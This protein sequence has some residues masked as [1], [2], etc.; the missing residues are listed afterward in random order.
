MPRLRT[1]AGP[2]KLRA[3][4]RGT[5]G[6]PLPFQWTYVQWLVTLVSVPV[7]VSVLWIVLNALGVRYAGTW[8]VPWGAAAAMYGSV[9]VMRHVSY[10]EPLRHVQQTLRQEWRNGSVARLDRV[11]VEFELP[12]IR[13]LAAPTLRAMGWTAAHQVPLTASAASPDSDQDPDA[14]SYWRRRVTEQDTAVDSQP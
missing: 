7:V 5:K 12:P 8:A 9:K 14:D 10:D 1:D 6:A 2:R 4:W 11:A 13:Y 3:V